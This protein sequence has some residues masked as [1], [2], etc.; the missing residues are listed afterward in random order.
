MRTKTIV[1]L[2]TIVLIMLGLV[3]CTEGEIG[4]ISIIK[5]NEKE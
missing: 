3:A 4:E 5:E 2:C 1:L